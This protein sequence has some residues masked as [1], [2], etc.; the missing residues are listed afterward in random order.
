M[1]R[2]KQDNEQSLSGTLKPE[3]RPLSLFAACLKRE[4][5]GSEIS[6]NLLPLAALADKF[7]SIGRRYEASKGRGTQDHK[8]K[9]TPACTDTN[10]NGCTPLLSHLRGEFPEK[11]SER[12]PHFC[13][14][15]GILLCSAQFPFRKPPDLEK[16]QRRFTKVESDIKHEW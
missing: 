15:E 11:I 12:N 9:K 13:G 8:R 3:T 5:F 4:T 6:S 2:S 14:T 7:F 16:K 10:N 1:E